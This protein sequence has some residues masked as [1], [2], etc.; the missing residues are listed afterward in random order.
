[1]ARPER[2][3]LEVWQQFL[4][5]HQRV[6]GVLGDELEQERGLPLAWYEVLLHVE[7]APD[8]RLRMGDLADAVVLSPSGLT[9]LVDRMVDD[10]LVRRE[11]CPSDRRSTYAVLTADGRS[12]L[13]RAAPTHLRGIDE[14]FARLLTD[15]EV[16]VLSRALGRV[17]D[18]LDE[19]ASEPPPRAP[20][21]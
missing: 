4:R 21:A 7:R 8:R 15:D 17:L 11:P 10:G 3:R 14:H 2:S 18:A 5:A 19:P 9:R 12:A 6:L 13:R 16:G 20:S 1:M